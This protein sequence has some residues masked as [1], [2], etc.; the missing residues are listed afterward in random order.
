MKTNEKNSWKSYHGPLSVQGLQIILS[1]TAL[2]VT[3]Q[4]CVFWQPN[5]KFTFT[6][7]LVKFR[8]SNM[9]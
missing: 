2:L 4:M 7:G 3:V 5:Y 9:S 8:L 1:P 6:L